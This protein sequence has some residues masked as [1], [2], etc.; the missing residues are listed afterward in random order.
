MV[1]RLVSWEVFRELF[2]GG[3]NSLQALESLEITGLRIDEIEESY[4]NTQHLT[5]PQQVPSKVRR[6]TFNGL[7]GNNKQLLLTVLDLFPNVENLAGANMRTL[8]DY[9]PPNKAPAF[10]PRS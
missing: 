8:L 4:L 5:Q 9:S 10:I 3:A 6:L 7:F 1:P 2:E